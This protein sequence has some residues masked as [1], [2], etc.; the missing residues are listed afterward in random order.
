MSKG[1]QEWTKARSPRLHCHRRLHPRWLNRSRRSGLFASGARPSIVSSPPYLSC[2]SIAAL[3]AR[4]PPP[5]LSCSSIRSGVVPR[6]QRGG[7]EEGERGSEGVKPSWN[8]K[9]E[10]R[11]QANL[12]TVTT[13]SGDRGWAGSGGL[14]L[15]LSCFGSNGLGPRRPR[16][17]LGRTVPAQSVETMVS[18]NPKTRHAFVGPYGPSSTHISEPY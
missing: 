8:K 18:P 2:P 17:R 12:W 14:G 4:E 9:K 10:W 16:K 6:H 7:L 5:S 13:T 3:P 15:G 11:N 1:H